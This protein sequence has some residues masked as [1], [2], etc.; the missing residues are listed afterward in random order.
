M[1]LKT[2][3]LIL[4]PL[5]MDDLNVVH[6]LH[7]HPETDKFNTLGIPENK[8]VTRSIIQSWLENQNGPSYTYIIEQKTDRAFVGVISLSNSR[9]KWHRGELW[10][11]LHKDHWCKGYATEA[12]K[13]IIRFAFETLNMHRVEAGCAVD[14]IASARVMEKAGMQLEGR[15]RKVLPIRGQWCDAFSYAILDEDYFRRLEEQKQL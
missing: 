7:S 13:E 6:N 3:R 14:N 10:Y 8:D 9:N 12:V 4:R 2:E 15:K 5:T 1:N 11:K